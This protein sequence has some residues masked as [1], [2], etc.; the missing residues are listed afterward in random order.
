[1]E[2]QNNKSDIGPII[3]IIIVILMLVIGAFYFYN[4]RIEKQKEITKAN[5]QQEQIINEEGLSTLENTAN[6]L[7]FDNLGE[8]IDQL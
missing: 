7:N 4:Q 1:M 2:G 5:Q 6:S 3:G 8:G